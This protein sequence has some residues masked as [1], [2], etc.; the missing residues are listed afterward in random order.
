MGRWHVI[1]N[2]AEKYYGI[3]TYA[4]A[5]DNPIRFVDPDGNEIVD[6]TG[7]RITYSKKDGWSSNATDDV[8][9]I[10]AG[11]VQTKTG[12]KQW[13]KAYNS[14]SKIEMN[15]VE[16]KLYAKDGG[17]ALGKTDQSLAENIKTG[18]HIK[19]D[20]TMQIRVSTGTIKESFN[21]KNK[22]LT[23]V[24]AIAATA[25]HEIEHTTEE[26]RDIGVL[27]ATFGVDVGIEK[28]PTKIGKQIRKESRALPK[29]KKL[30]NHLIT[31]ID[32]NTKTLR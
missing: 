17:L 19:T 12:R 2:K 25:R 26:N 16:K 13:G 31:D 28:K 20:K 32:I 1:D 24:Q 27:N 11:L 14:D 21:G 5:I 18:K 22:G 10:H 8:K 29:L 30:E 15:V 6:A 4:Y 7:V 9:M 23:M 3:T